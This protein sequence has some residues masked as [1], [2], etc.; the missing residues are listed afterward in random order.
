VKQIGRESAEPLTQSSF[1]DAAK[2]KIINQIGSENGQP[3]HSYKTSR[4]PRT[5]SAKDKLTILGNNSQTKP[6][7]TERKVS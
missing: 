5:S 2:I 4:I 1:L 6:G 7:K 3:L